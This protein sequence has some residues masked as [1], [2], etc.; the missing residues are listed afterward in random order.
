GFVDRRGR[1]EEHPLRPRAEV[2][3]QL[4]VRSP[5]P[6]EH[7]AEYSVARRAILRPPVLEIVSLVDDDQIERR[8]RRAHGAGHVVLERLLAPEVEDLVREPRQRPAKPFT[9]LPAG[10]VVDLVAAA[11]GEAE[12]RQPKEE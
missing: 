7:E 9:P 5:G 6:A 8:Q 12:A 1:E 10:V 4:L 11:E 2:R 3:K